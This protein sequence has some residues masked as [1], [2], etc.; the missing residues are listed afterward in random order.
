MSEL[1]F[2]IEPNNHNTGLDPI[3]AQPA[4]PSLDRQSNRQ[5]DDHHLGRGMSLSLQNILP[6]PV[7]FM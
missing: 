6:G 4:A 5:T 7:Y 2:L 3:C 1:R